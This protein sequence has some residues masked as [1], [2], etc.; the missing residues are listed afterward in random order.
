MELPWGQHESWGKAERGNLLRGQQGPALGSSKWRCWGMFG[1]QPGLGCYV[2]QSVLK[3][4]FWVP[5]WQCGHCLGPCPWGAVA[6]PRLITLLGTAALTMDWQQ[7]PL[8]SSSFFLISLLKMKQTLTFPSH[9][10]TKSCDFCHHCP[11]NGVPS[12]SQCS[13]KLVMLGQVWDPCWEHK[14]LLFFR[15]ALL[16]SPLLMQCLCSQKHRGFFPCFKAV[17]QSC[18]LCA[19][20]WEYIYKNKPRFSWR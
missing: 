4:L 10:P 11:L 16:Q 18:N 5:D 2:S 20:V 9:W 12:I 19:Y 17:M 8:T 15:T 14:D 7:Q 3:G 13:S 1:H 6:L